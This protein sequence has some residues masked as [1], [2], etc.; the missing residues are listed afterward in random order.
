[1][2]NGLTFEELYTWI[3]TQQ[4]KLQSFHRLLDFLKGFDLLE[5]AWSSTSSSSSPTFLFLR[6]PESFIFYMD[7]QLRFC[8]PVVID[9]N[10]KRRSQVAILLN[11]FAS[12]KNGARITLRINIGVEGDTVRAIL[13]ASNMGSLSIM[14]SS[15]STLHWPIFLLAKHS[16]WEAGF[17][18]RPSPVMHANRQA[19]SKE[20][21]RRKAAITK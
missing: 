17:G 2:Q 5:W 6:P 1:M 18:K 11:R 16:Q 15:G 4:G 12:S 10:R 20:G 9:C 21:A 3:P 7:K 8:E 14:I 13:F 19:K